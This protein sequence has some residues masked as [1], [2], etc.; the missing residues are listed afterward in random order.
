[1]SNKSQRVR[2]RV[3]AP[4]GTRN[5][6]RL[7]T[8]PDGTAVLSASMARG[9]QRLGNSYETSVFLIEGGLEGGELTVDFGPILTRV[10][11]YLNDSGKPLEAWELSADI[12][13]ALD[14]IKARDYPDRRAEL[15]QAGVL[16]FFH[17]AKGQH[18]LTLRRDRQ[19]RT[20]YSLDGS[21]PR[22]LK[23]LGEIASVLREAGAQAELDDVQEEAQAQRFAAWRESEAARHAADQARRKPAAPP[24]G[25]E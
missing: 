25:G 19:G 4:Y 18:T 14:A 20:A 13:A 6:Y 2:F 21:R 3:V 12:R 17:S 5:G 24:S 16:A 23:Y 10:Q 15:D 22:L 8:A 7:I 9:M 1:M 11:R